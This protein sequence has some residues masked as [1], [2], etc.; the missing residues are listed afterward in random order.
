M[1]CRHS[2]PALDEFF[3]LCNECGAWRRIGATE[4]NVPLNGLY[5]EGVPVAD[6]LA[7]S[8]ASLAAARGTDEH[9]A[10]HKRIA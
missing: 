5:P 9:R 2:S 6:V 1:S 3:E 10:A 8:E 4:W 7:V